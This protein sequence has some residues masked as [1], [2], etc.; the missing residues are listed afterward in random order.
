M[1]KLAAVIAFTFC[2]HDVEL[3]SLIENHELGIGEDITGK[4][5]FSL[6]YYPYNVQRD[7]RAGN[8]KCT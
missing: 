4:V 1:T 3:R 7:Q 8:L 6:V 5:K 2:V